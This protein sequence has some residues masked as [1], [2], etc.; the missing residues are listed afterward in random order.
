MYAERARTGQERDRIGLGI[1]I[2]QMTLSED[3][4]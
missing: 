3:I 1:D 4:R 2:E